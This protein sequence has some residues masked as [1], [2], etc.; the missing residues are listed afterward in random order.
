MLQKIGNKM[1]IN[2][3][4]VWCRALPDIKSGPEVRQF[5]KIQTVQKLDVFLPGRRTFNTFENDKETKKKIVFQNVFSKIIFQDFFLF[6]Y[7]V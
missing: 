5:F 3:F 1:G 4:V 6:I 7:L 2:S